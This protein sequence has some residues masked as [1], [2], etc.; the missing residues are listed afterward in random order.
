MLHAYVMVEDAAEKDLARWRKLGSTGEVGWVATVSGRVDAIVGVHG[1][2]L[3]ALEATV[4]GVIRGSGEGNVK[5]RT[6][7]QVAN[8]TANL[9]LPT[10]PQP[11]PTGRA[12][13]STT[14]GDVSA[15]L[16]IRVQAGKLERVKRA[17]MKLDGHQGS[18]VVSGEF[19]ILAHF[20]AP[21]IKALYAV[22]VDGIHETGGVV[23]TE[24]SFVT[25]VIVPGGATKVTKGPRTT[26][27][28]TGKS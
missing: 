16:L 3:Q 2:D 26:V 24:T 4:R 6:A 13:M 15:F 5:T 10:P 17:I 11:G 27:T 12:E 7:L 14:Q 22:V 8:W 18:V 28:R 20:T 9:P 1:K 25:S 23:S 21:S 19:D